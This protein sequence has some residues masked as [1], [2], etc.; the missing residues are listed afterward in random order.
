MSGLVSTL[1][2]RQPDDEGGY[3]QSTFTNI[4]LQFSDTL[5]KDNP[6]K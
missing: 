3:L 4:T 1:P 2:Y 6:A 5:R